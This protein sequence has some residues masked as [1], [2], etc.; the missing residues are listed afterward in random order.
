MLFME[1]PFV[2]SLPEELE[3]LFKA[4]SKALFKVSEALSMEITGP[5]IV[6]IIFAVALVIFVIFAIVKGQ[7]RK[8][9]TGVENMVGKVAVTQTE[10]NPTGT[11][12]AEGELWT[13]IAEGS[14]IKA[15]EEVVI[16][17]VAGLKLWVTKKSKE[18]EEK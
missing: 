17:K 7:R 14:K 2:E 11:V 15:D 6:V 13:A 10:L 3:A 1:S 12:L 9:T 8:L 5:I 4:L 16:T 18:R